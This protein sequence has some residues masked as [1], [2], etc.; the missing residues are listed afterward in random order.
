MPPVPRLVQVLPRPDRGVVGQAPPDVRRVLVVPPPR[1][2]DLVLALPALAALRRAYPRAWIAVVATP[3]AAPLARLSPV[4]DQVL[5]HADGIG[6]FDPLVRGF[7]PTVLLAQAPTLA[8]AF[9]ARRAK[10]PLSVGPGDRAFSRLFTRRV[11]A[12]AVR[13]LHQVEEALAYAHGAGARPGPAEF[14]LTVPPEV[15]EGLAHWRGAHRVPARYVAL[16]AGHGG[17]SPA[18][19]LNHFLRLAALLDAEGLSVVL[20]IGPLDRPVWNALDRAELPIRRLPRLAAELPV[21]AGLLRGAG[22]LVGNTS[23][24]VHLA[25]ALGTPTLAFHPPGP[26]YGPER[27]G[28]YAGNGWALVADGERGHVWHRRSRR[29]ASSLLEG[30]SPAAALACVLDLAE[31][32]EP[33]L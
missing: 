11:P 21:L 14:P 16:H 2:G 4:I 30:I 5:V 6:D 23:G 9:A 20:S 32:R 24:P 28:P 7:R 31:G 26:L 25:A 17:S 18:W 10:V 12:R 19:P 29:A 22:V 1:L 8:L 33:R 27:C 13:G 3:L 15:E